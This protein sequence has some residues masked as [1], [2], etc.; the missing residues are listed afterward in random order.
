[1]KK[2]A[3]KNS[4]KEKEEIA[5]IVSEVV[6]ESEKEQEIEVMDTPSSVEKEKEVIAEQDEKTESEPED[7]E[8]EGEVTRRASFYEKVMGEEK[9]HEVQEEVSDEKKERSVN[10]KLLLLG[11]FVFV[12]TVLISS[13]VGLSILNKDLLITKIGP[14]A[15][16]T[17]T[18]LPATPTPPAFARSEWSFEVLNGSD[19]PGL[20]A[21]GAEKIKALGY[22]V[23][24][25]GNADDSVDTTQVLISK[26]AS[27]QQKTSILADLRPDFG[28][29]AF[30]DSLP[31][32]EKTI[33]IILAK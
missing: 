19:T 21:K 28:E 30:T 16:T 25:V 8:K 12:L 32:A 5:Q 4:P 7:S 26:D 29:L 11:A 22:K 24:K 9:P 15:T 14:K 27:E 1:M 6:E 17:P 31:D 23:G 20:A 3:R 18:P 33:R 2:P 13:L 10:T